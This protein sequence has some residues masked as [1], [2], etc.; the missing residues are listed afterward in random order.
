LDSQNNKK[1]IYVF[2]FHNISQYITNIHPS[3]NKMI[4]NPKALIYSVEGNIGAGKTTFLRAIEHSLCNQ[5]RTDIRVI[6]EPVDNWSKIKDDEGKT[7]LQ[8]FY[9]NP[10]KYAFPFQIMAFSSRL[11]LLR[12]EIKKYPD[13]KIFLCER[14]LEADSQVFAKMLFEDGL[15]D[16][17]SYQ[18]YRQLYENGI[19]E[20][21]VSK[22][23]YLRM[24]P[25]TCMNR[26]GLRQREGE[27][28]IT[29]DYLKK[30]HEYHETWLNAHDKPNT[31]LEN[32][33]DIETFICTI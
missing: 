8:N 24:E 31:L 9:E 16:T 22:T 21:A 14:S 30:C 17:M 13:C 1:L 15:M 19:G 18:I 26:V 11:N 29:L 2:L 4:Q 12:E 33:S 3:R 23:I 7:I 5:G 28:T 20:Y 10:A 25:E 27:D 32:D 6:Y